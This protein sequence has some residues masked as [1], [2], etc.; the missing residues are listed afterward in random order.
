MP[1]FPEKTP[2][3]I[4]DNVIDYEN[5]YHL[6][7][8]LGSPRQIA[9]GR[10][11]RHQFLE[12]LLPRIVDAARGMAPEVAKELFRCVDDLRNSRSANQWIEEVRGRRGDAVAYAFSL[13]LKAAEGREK[14]RQA[15]LEKQDRLHRAA[16][17]RRIA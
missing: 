15:E 1:Y 11:I 3:E 13:P 6:P 16:E 5:E 12:E 2:I 10:V 4:P 14:Q 8:L 7:T 17:G 9:W